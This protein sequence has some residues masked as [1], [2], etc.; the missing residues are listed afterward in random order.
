MSYT[1]R[2]PSDIALTLGRLLPA[3]FAWSG[4]RPCGVAVTI[5]AVSAVHSAAAAPILGVGVSQQS[6]S[7]GIARDQESTKSVDPKSGVDESTS[8]QAT[9]DAKI[10]SRPAQSKPPKSLDELLGVPSSGASGSSAEGAA[11]REQTRRLE[12]A[13][14]EASLED[15]VDRAVGGMRSAAERLE[16]ARDPG[17]GTQRIQEDVV[18]TLARLLEEAERQSQSKSKSSSSRRSGSRRSANEDPSEANGQ[19]ASQRDARSSQVAGQPQ[20]GDGDGESTPDRPA[21]QATV[22]GIELEESRIEWGQ[23]P[24]RARELVLQGRRDRVSSIY[25]RL[26]REYYRR[27][28]EEA[29]K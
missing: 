17:I 2:L 20:S 27:L 13:L 1:D 26:T 5:L 8:R 11:E 7:G 16:D 19:Q 22:D 4:W 21:D 12:R 14:E 24:E 29:S 28:A 10:A 25:E 9:T 3:S 6:A 18:R 15:L 23:L